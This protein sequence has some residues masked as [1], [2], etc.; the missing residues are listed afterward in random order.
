MQYPGAIYHVINRGDRQEA[1]FTD[2]ADRHRRVQTLGECF[3]KTGWQFRA[4]CPTPDHTDL[5]FFP[6]DF[7]V[8]IWTA[9]G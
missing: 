5:S 8:F 4:W 2:D 9:S 7:D 3:A 1:I 6:S